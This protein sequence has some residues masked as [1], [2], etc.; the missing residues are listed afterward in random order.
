MTQTSYAYC[1]IFPGIGIARL[2]NS[3]KDFFF[4]PEVPGVVPDHGG[5][6]KDAQGRVKRQAARFRV[7]A[8]NSQDQIVA[9]LTAD[10]PDVVALTWTVTLAN[11]K[12]EWYTFAGTQNV[13]NILN[14][15]GDI[16]PRR[17]LQVQDNERQGLVIGPTAT[18]V[19]G[20]NQQSSPL[21]GK[22]LTKST[23]IYLGEL[24]TDEAGRLL[25]LGGRGESDTILPDNPLAHYANNDGWHD[26]T[27]DGPV[28]VVVALKNGN[29]LEVRGRGWVIVAPP[30]FS[31]YTKN[32]VTLYDAMTQAVLDNNLPWPE[33]ELGP[34]PSDDKVSFTKHIYPILQ[35]LVMSQ[36][37]SRRAQRGHAK[38][39]PGDFLA[40]ETLCQLANPDCARQPGSLHQHIFTRLRT[41]ILHSPAL[42]S[43]P[44]EEGRL[45]PRS[46]EAINQANLYFMPPVAGDEGDVKHGDPKTWFALTP[47]QYRKLRKWK[48]GEFV[49][50]WEKLPPLPVS[51]A[52]IPV[53]EQPAS[54]TRATL[55]A[56]QGGAFFPG[57]EITSIFRFASFYSEAFCVSNDYSPGDITK[58]M[59]VPWQADFY[60]CRDHWWP[61]IRPDDVIPEAEY[62]RILK[63]FQG[64]AK[65]Q[66]LT[67]LL[68]VRQPWARG[69]A[70]A[71]PPRPE[72]PDKSCA[73]TLQQYQALC[74]GQ[75]EKFV[76]GFLNTIPKPLVGEVGDLYRRRL[77]EFLDKTVREPDTCPL[78]PFQSGETLQAYFKRVWTMLK[79]DLTSQVEVPSPNPEETLSAY[80]SRLA[81][82][83]TGKMVWQ[84]LYDTEWRRR[85][86]HHGKNDLAQHWSRLGFIVPRTTCG[87]T[88]YVES[89]RHWYDLLGFREY[90]YYLLNIEAYPD[91]LP[92]ARQL[93]E[94]YLQQAWDREPKLRAD[95]HREQYGFFDYDVVTFQARLE[96]IYEIERRL[97][98]AYNPITYKGEPLFRTPTRVVER[99]RQMAPFNHL[100]GAWLEKITRAGPINEVQ[101]LLFEIWS[102][103]IGNGD[104][105]HNHANVYSDLLHSAGI[106][107]PP[108]AS[109]TYA[110]NPEI[111]DAS[112]S[113]PVYQLAIAHFPASYYPELL[114]MTLHLEWE[115]VSLTK[116][117]KLYTAHGY[118]PLFYRLHVAIDN[119]VSGHGALAR[120]AVM[121]YLDHVRNESGEREMQEHWRRI[122]TGYLA[123][124][125]VGGPDWQ[126]HLTNPPTVEE[127][128]L[129]MFAHKRHYAQLNHGNRRFGV[130]SINDWFD[131]PEAFLE[132]L[133]ASDLIVKGD[134][135]NSKIFALMAFNGPMLKVFS[136][137]DKELWAEWINSLPRDPLGTALKPGQAM[138]ALLRKFRARGTAVPDHQNFM[139]RGAFED[140]AQPGQKVQVEK[141]VSWWFQIN[142]PERMMEALA[143]PRNG[144][145]LCGNVAESRLVRELLSESRPMARF[146]SQTIP[147]IGHKTAWQVIIDW[148]VA[149]CPPAEPPAEPVPVQALATPTMEWVQADEYARE[150]QVRSLHSVRLEREQRQELRHRWYGPGGGAAH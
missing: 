87:E 72:L 75:L 117:V 110:D 2:G 49:N 35:R 91:F 149:C 63:A 30:H 86:Q 34:K 43:Q 145:I 84:G 22:F 116:M 73:Q 48:D 13:A 78:P 126:Y 92:K 23:N 19:T 55:E 134:A 11:K 59:A 122:W 93:T 113:S 83:A 107:L 150:I 131:E 38:G 140:P 3:P 5:S 1:K 99:I 143:D 112:F 142:Q 32:V 141:P 36:W 7:Y 57:I 62:E 16:S 118:N 119:P 96:K 29:Q 27:A 89:D 128:L 77:E 146:L 121:L 94:E 88:V 21:E 103:E 127:R 45:D 105:T 69:L 74:Q 67:S 18:S 71:L 82:C 125:F 123:F 28:S 139:L 68:T 40:P 12:A 147:E 79:A 9:E 41:P 104:P 65:A 138:R 56:C 100:D 58:W 64:E 80:A 33:A 132:E 53:S 66:D 90:F 50:D 15:S 25:V 51:F 17:N 20:R 61:T 10:H 70:L 95:P 60:E 76:S 52:D 31:P 111:W 8:F 26:D 44:P 85:V 42:E 135:A 14:Q 148:I 108:I 144:W 109:R 98:Q 46:Q 136:T 54:L 97:A 47:L 37:V 137:Q 24:Q 81:K 130:N 124:K 120:Q 39:K 115:A 106:Y 4:G 6:Y 102:D 114:G 129:A 101:S 133:A